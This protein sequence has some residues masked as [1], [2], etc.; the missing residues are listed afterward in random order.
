MADFTACFSQAW[1]A[2]RNI[3]RK[4]D[5]A[6]IA[7]QKIAQKARSQKRIHCWKQTP[8]S[9]RKWQY[10]KLQATQI[11]SAQFLAYKFVKL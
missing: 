3:S 10:S 4:G 11:L 8:L 2:L 7:K 6:V 1:H 9:R 5:C